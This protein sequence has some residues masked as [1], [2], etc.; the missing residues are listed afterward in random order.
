MVT[1]QEASK[2]TPEYMR[3]WE[4]RLSPRQK[5]FAFDLV[6]GWGWKR[7]EIPPMY[8]WAEAYRKA[9]TILPERPL[10]RCDDTST[11]HNR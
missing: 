11:N 7:Y 2:L 10:E 4:S 9:E 3:A 1:D 8:V 5:M 6:E